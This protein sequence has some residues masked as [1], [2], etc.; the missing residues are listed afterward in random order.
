VN[1][2]DTI[3]LAGVFTLSTPKGSLHIS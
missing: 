3:T 1:N 2:G